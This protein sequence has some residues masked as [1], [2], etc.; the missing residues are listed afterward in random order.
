MDATWSSGLAVLQRSALPEGY[1]LE[2][3]TSQDVPWLTA[4]LARWYPD[5][6]AGMESPHLQPAFYLTQTQLAD[7]REPRRARACIRRAHRA[8][9]RGVV[10]ALR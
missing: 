8:H 4:A 6:H 9:A 1:V 3:L 10:G 2:Q 5:I 7:Q